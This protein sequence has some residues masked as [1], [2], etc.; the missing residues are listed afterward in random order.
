MKTLRFLI[1]L[2]ALAACPP[3]INVDVCLPNPCSGDRSVC[4]AVDGAAVCFCRAGF[5]DVAGA[6]VAPGPCAANPCTESNRTTC[7]AMG[8]TAV[9]R[10]D[11]GFL[12]NAQGLCVR[13]QSCD[14]NPCSMPN[15]TTCSESNGVVSCAC[16][17]GFRDDG[18]GGCV[19]D[20]PCASNPCTEPNRGQCSVSGNAAVCRCDSGFIE[21][22]SGTC[23]RPASCTPNPCTD[24]NKTVCSENNGVV[25][26]ACDSGY[27]LDAAGQCIPMQA[28]NPNP[29][30]QPNRG[31]CTANNGVAICGCNAGYRDQAGTCVLDDACDPNPC[32]QPNRGVCTASNGTAICGCNAGFQ[33][34]AGTCVAVDV[35]A[36]NPCNQP[37]RGVC[38]ALNGTAVCGCNAGFQEMNGACVQ[39]DACNPNPCT[40]PN[41]GV[42]AAV[43]GGAS[44]ACNTGYQD[45]PSGCEVIPP[46]TCS[47]Q[48]TAGDMYEP[49][50]CPALAKLIVPGTPQQHTFAPAGDV[51]WVMFNADDGTVVLAEETG[52]IASLLSLYGSNGTAAI[53]TNG[54]NRVHV[55]VADTGTYFL[56]VRAQTAS[57]MGNTTIAVTLSSD[58]HADSRDGNPS[59]LAPGATVNG[60]FNFPSDVDCLA[61]PV[62][63]NRVYQFEETTPLDVRLTIFT[64]TSTYI[65]RTDSESLRFKTSAAETLFLC[66]EASSSSSLSS[67]ALRVTDL[68]V[69]DHADSRSDNPATLTPSASPGNS[70]TGKFD[71]TGDVDCLAVPVQSGRVYTFAETSSVD[72][73]NTVF[74]ATGTFI[75]STDDESRRFLSQ[76]TETLYFC[77]RAYSSSNITN[78]TLTVTDNGVDDHANARSENPATMLPGAM[79]TG[80]FNYPGDVD[81][82]A[83]PVIANRIYSF[84]ETSSTDVYTAIYTDTT[85]VIA[86]DDAELHRIKPALTQTL[87]FCTR[88]YSSSST[89]S[90]TL[91]VT[92]EGVDDHVNSRDDI[93]MTVTPTGTVSGQFQYPYDIECIAVPVQ[94][95]R[96][97]TFAETTSVDVYLTVY[98]ATDTYI[99]QTDSESLRFESLTAQTLFLCTRAYSSSSVSAWALTV[100]DEGVDDHVDSR[101]DNPVTLTPGSTLSGKFDTGS[102]IDCVAVPVVA[103]HGYTFEETTATDVY[104]T[105]Y[106]ATATLIART[107]SEAVHFKA[108]S[109]QTLFLCTT[110]Y[111]SALS[112]WTLRVTD[113]GEDDHA[114]TRTGATSLTVGGAA[115]NGQLQFSGDS[116]YFTFTTTGAVALRVIT[117]GVATAVRVENSAGTSIATGTGPTTTTFSVSA[118]GTYFVRVSPGSLGA[119]T[120]TVAN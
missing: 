99:T 88:A 32:T 115:V 97:Y 25:S 44:C 33:D 43:D 26:C 51:D 1:P 20:D 76:T 36:P 45:G 100:T 60:T 70:L 53:A 64:A 34:Q 2:F 67:W 23:I 107:D 30:T 39:L 86:Q 73:V 22:A 31:V 119:Y 120:V 48:H 78:W 56:Q 40:Q 65:P 93:P 10:C 4:T 77:T 14:P 72:V 63:A 47:T 18:V 104:L 62:Q 112:N 102:D 105:V 46:P 96:I 111:S 42:C 66:V 83:V 8:S 114:D 11:S 69:D 84:A 92:D 108:A 27:R 110:G 16:D 3:V 54:L 59:Q 87:Y 98:T 90:W 28:C 118:A 81:C 95:G 24:P 89:A 117:T 50:E 103:N 17:V 106:T 71:F 35:C 79:V 49:D 57:N 58:D 80:Q 15:K 12:E 94:A 6:C 37:N 75:A 113:N 29:C 55:K 9:C 82:L 41:R 91:R 52:T 5:Q 101:D 7:V 85:T 68:G 74:T 38:T 13:A 19:S 116:D 61:V 21:D 109:S